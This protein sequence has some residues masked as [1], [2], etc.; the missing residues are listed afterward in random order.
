MTKLMSW[1]GEV[2]EVDG[3]G[4]L[5]L[6]VLGVAIWATTKPEWL[7]MR[8]LRVKKRSMMRNGERERSMSEVEAKC[9]KE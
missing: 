8:T 5:S 3:R 2:D 1:G 9:D 4:E 7:G 6:P